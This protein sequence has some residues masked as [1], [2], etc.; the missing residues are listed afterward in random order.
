MPVQIEIPQEA[1]AAFCRQHNIRRLSL[2]GSVLR[3]DFRPDSD[4][5][6]LVE[7]EAGAVV[8]LFDIARME[9]ELSPLFGRKVDLRTPGDLSRY[10]RDSVLA[11]AE[12][13]YE[14][15]G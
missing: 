5:D 8:G 1:I 10:F 14:R 6:V 2:F 12:V 3:D 13:Q 11:M 4:V 15:T 9:R 7:F